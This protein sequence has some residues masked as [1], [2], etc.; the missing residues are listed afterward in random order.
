MKLESYKGPIMR[1]KIKQLEII[2][3]ISTVKEE[4]DQIMV[5]KEERNKDPSENREERRKI[6]PRRRV[7]NIP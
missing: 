1:R 7:R 2:G 5:D 4:K 6:I 3:E